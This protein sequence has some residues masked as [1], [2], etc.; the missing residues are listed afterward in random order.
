[1]PFGS[2]EAT[3]S[4]VTGW[5]IAPAST[6][7]ITVD[8]YVDGKYVSTVAADGP[9]PD[10]GAAWPAYGAAHGFSVALPA[11]SSGRHTVCAY[12]V[13]TDNQPA[14]ELGC[15]SLGANDQLAGA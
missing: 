3:K 1:V 4:V 2:L 12:G 6:A 8:L 9:R 14:P 10:V 13:T 11:L 15:I 5:A 7:S